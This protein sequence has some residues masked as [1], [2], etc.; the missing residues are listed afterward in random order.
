MHFFLHFGT[1]GLVVLQLNLASKLSEL[2]QF[3]NLQQI[4]SYRAKNGKDETKYLHKY[5]NSFYNLQLSISDF[6]RA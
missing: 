2:E 6:G 5:L 3:E 4:T 1:F